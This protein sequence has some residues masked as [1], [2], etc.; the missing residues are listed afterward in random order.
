MSLV[1][2]SPV[3]FYRQSSE[4]GPVSKTLNCMVYHKM[5]VHNFPGVMMFNPLDKEFADDFDR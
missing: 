2:S 5:Q 3:L 4:A 1:H